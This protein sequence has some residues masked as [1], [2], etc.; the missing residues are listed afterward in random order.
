M[1]GG[2]GVGYSDDTN[3]DGGST[4]RA[5]ETVDVDNI[6]DGGAAL[7]VGWTN[8]GEWL[9][10]TTNPG[11]WTT[12]PTFAGGTYYAAFRVAS[13]AGGGRYRVEV[14]GKI[15][16]SDVGSTGG[17]DT[18]TTTYSGGMPISAGQHT[19]KFVAD[20]GGFNVNYVEL[21][22]VAPTPTPQRP[23]SIPTPAG[24]L[25]KWGVREVYANGDQGSLDS[26]VASLNSGTGTI[27]DYQTSVINLHDSDPVTNGRLGNRSPFG[28]VAQGH[29]TKGSVDNLALVAG[30][31][32]KIPATG[33][34][35]FNVNS[36]DGFEFSVDGNLVHKADWGN[37]ADDQLGQAYLTA[38]NHNV[39][40]LYWEG[41]G[42]SS[43]QVSAAQ[44]YK[45]SFDGSF[46]LI[47]AP[48][49]PAVHQT[50]PSVT[51][52]QNSNHNGFD[53][54]VLYNMPGGSSL[55]AAISAVR[56]YWDSNITPIPSRVGTAVSN[57]INYRDPDDGQEWIHGKQMQNF[58]GTVAGDGADNDFVLGARGTMHVSQGGVYTFF[59]FGDDGSQFRIL[60]TT[61]EQWLARGTNHG[62]QWRLSSLADGFKFDGWG[63]DAWGTINLLPGDYDLELIWQEGGGGAHI[64]LF[65]KYGTWD[66]VTNPIF[67]L[68]DSSAIDL[69]A[70]PA[71]LEI[72]PE[73]ATMVLM[74]IGVAGLA[75]SR[76]RRSHAAI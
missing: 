45:T 44:G 13:G 74:G 23:L 60:G 1:T 62:D 26:V 12:S 70:V 59:T 32:V 34:Y 5:P 40:L 75:I 56:N 69:D 58:P 68:G 31:T 18:W 11:V 37:A 66:D 57:T 8:G 4:Y 48:A 42:G 21:S 39:R 24:S 43:V 51:N 27:V 76:R 3:R 49:L 52:T 28:V 71:G 6:N 47:G 36:D 54:T 61:D 38:G 17:W 41:G 63:A 67:L 7:G 72:M 29:A 50:P 19:V 33:W 30:A 2:N 25:G 10:L 46:N 9:I 20:T 55:D 14:D 64:G 15:G 22:Q 53:V 73:P 65:A 35:T 16:K